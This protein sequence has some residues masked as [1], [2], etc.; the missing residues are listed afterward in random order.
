[1]VEFF[2][3]VAEVIGTAGLG[4]VLVGGILWLMIHMGPKKS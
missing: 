3:F 1:M 2:R 4:T